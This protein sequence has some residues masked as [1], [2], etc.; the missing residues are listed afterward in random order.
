MDQH[1]LTEKAPSKYEF[2]WKALKDTTYKENQG[3]YH[4]T[5]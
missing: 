1:M 4:K 3:I 2:L 5:Q